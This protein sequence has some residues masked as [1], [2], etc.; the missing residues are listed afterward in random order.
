[1]SVKA[2]QIRNELIMGGNEANR[3]ALLGPQLQNESKKQTSL[4]EQIANNTKAT[5]E[6]TEEAT[7]EDLE[8]FNG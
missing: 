3:V 4:L 1:M 8:E 7:A 2:P 6:N 5:A